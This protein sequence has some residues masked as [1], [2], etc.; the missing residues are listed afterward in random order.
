MT[1]TGPT[2]T[3]PA[4]APAATVEL[5]LRLRKQ[6]AEAGLD[7]GADTIEWHLLHHHQVRLS[8]ATVHR[9]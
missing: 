9:I 7:A 5:V 4:A 6:L 2:K 1:L 8:R 3:S